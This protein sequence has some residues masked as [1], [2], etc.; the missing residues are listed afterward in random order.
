MCTVWV[1]AFD[2][3]TKPCPA[4]TFSEHSLVFVNRRPESVRHQCF[5]SPPPLQGGRGGVL[6]PEFEIRFRSPLALPPWIWEPAAGENFFGVIFG[7]QGGRSPLDL[8]SRFAPPWLSP[9]GKNPKINTVRHQSKFAE[10]TLGWCLCRSPWSK[11]TNWKFKCQIRFSVRSS[12]SKNAKLTPTIRFENL[13]TLRVNE[14]HWEKIYSIHFRAGSMI[15]TKERNRGW[16][17]GNLVRRQILAYSN[18][19]INIDRKTNRDH[20][21]R[22]IIVLHEN[23]ILVECLAVIVDAVSKRALWRFVFED[24]TLNSVIGFEIILAPKHK[25]N[26]IG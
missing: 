3:L 11:G 24:R 10:E 16:D 15:K 13:I 12:L 5:C 18:S 4:E 26:P 21:N 1:R 19:K 9:L 14:S 7:S 22:E 6:P 8:R 2:I 20:S 23:V 17:G 25:S